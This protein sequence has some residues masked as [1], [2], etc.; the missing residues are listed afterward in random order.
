MDA[1][2]HSLHA[3][4]DTHPKAYRPCSPQCAACMS[5]A[6]RFVAAQSRHV[7][8]AGAHPLHD[9]MY[10]PVCTE[11]TCYNATCKSINVPVCE[12]SIER[13][14]RNVVCISPGWE[15][16]A[17]HGSLSALG[18]D[19]LQSLLQLCPDRPCWLPSCTLSRGR[20]ATKHCLQALFC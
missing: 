19:L 3:P 5:A 11:L 8:P 7:M 18:L 1:F 16:L 12:V 6:S 15:V 9:N 14:S 20:H 10:I 17:E 2:A 4:P 13:D